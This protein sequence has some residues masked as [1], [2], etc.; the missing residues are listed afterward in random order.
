MCRI[1]EKVRGAINESARDVR[2][3]NTCGCEIRFNLTG[4]EARIVLRKASGN[5]ITEAGLAEVYFGSFQAGYPTT[6]AAVGLSGQTLIIRK[7]PNLP[8][9]KAIAQERRL[10]FDPELVRVILPYDW[11]YE[12][13]SIEGDL[14]PPRPGQTPGLR[15]LAYG[16][17]IT[18]GGDAARPTGTYAMRTAQRLGADLLNKAFAGSAHMD[19]AIA[20]YVAGRDDW[21]FATV[22]MGINV[23]RFWE[24]E[25]FERKVERFLSVICEKRPDKWVFCTD[26]FLCIHDLENREKIGAFREAAA[27]TAEK[28]GHP[29]LRYF[30][31]TELLTSWNGLSADLVHPSAAGQE[32]IAANFASKIAQAMGR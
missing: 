14:A 9:L 24:T 11:I 19:E 7:P 4:E 3:Y 18:H 16:S 8:Q 26:L 31:G 6:P 2:A 29:K 30:P 1:P 12:I 15:F 10:P 23:I 5:S 13:V 25:L 27:K 21:D 32:E 22:E 20:E 28:L 17:S